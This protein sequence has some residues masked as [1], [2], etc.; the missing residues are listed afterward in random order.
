MNNWITVLYTNNDQ[1]W[2]QIFIPNKHVSTKIIQ[3][4]SFTATIYSSN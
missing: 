2:K 3:H 4:S 1:E